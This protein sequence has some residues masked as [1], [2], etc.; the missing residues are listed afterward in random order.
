MGDVCPGWFIACAAL[1]DTNV[2]GQ[3]EMYNNYADKILKE[4]SAYYADALVYEHF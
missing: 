4:Y 2:A 3:S 1:R